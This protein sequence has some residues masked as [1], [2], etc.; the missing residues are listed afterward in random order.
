MYTA[1]NET[2]IILSD[3]KTLHADCNPIAGCGNFDN[4]QVKLKSGAASTGCVTF[5]VPKSEQVIR[6]SYGNTVFPGTTAEWSM[7]AAP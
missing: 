7:P 6:V 3:G 2:T 5:Q 4:G 1:N